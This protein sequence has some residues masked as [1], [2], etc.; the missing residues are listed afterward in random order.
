MGFKRRGA[1][2]YAR[3]D[4]G[5]MSMTFT[6]EKST[7]RLS[8]QEKMTNATERLSLEMRTYL[9]CPL[10]SPPALNISGGLMLSEGTTS[11]KEMS[12]ALPQSRQMLSEKCQS[13]S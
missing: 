2:S 5:R 11:I 1:M 13:N 6:L 12:G 8:L 10:L 4:S 7:T 3:Q 9:H